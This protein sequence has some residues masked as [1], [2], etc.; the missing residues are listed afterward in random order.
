MTRATPSAEERLRAAEEIVGHNFSDPSLLRRAL[1]HPSHSD[2]PS[3]TLGDYERLEFLGDS[4]LGLVVVEEVFRRFPELTEGVL[5]K[6]KIALVAGATLTEVAEELDLGQLVLFGDSEL[7][8]G[9]R[10]MA[11]ALENVFEALVGAVYLDGG[12]PVARRFVLGALGD[13]ISPDAAEGL[14][15]PKSL[16]QESLQ[17]RG[18]APSYEIV[19]QSGPPHDRTFEARVRVGDEVAGT[20]IGRTKKS[21]E[22]NAAADAVVRLGII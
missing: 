18:L 11:S 16:L 9:G 3:S 6:I 14:E 8:T 21:A 1:T 7:A 2:T 13:R 4:V 12:L 5:T 19:R 10:G 15:H 22:M 17:A 20:G